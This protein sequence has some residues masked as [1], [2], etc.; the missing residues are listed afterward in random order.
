M[1]ILLNIKQYCR[2]LIII[3]CGWLFNELYIIVNVFASQDKSTIACFILK[4][5]LPLVSGY[6]LLS[7]VCRNDCLPCP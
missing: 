1:I 4:A 7:L 2:K 5:N 6:L 3:M